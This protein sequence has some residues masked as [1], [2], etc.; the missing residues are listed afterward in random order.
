M[1]A[2]YKI[3]ETISTAISLRDF[4]DK[5]TRIMPE[6]M[7]SYLLRKNNDCW[8]CC[9]TVSTIDKY[10][11]ITHDDAL[12]DII[13]SFEVKQTIYGQPSLSVM[14]EVFTPYIRF[15]VNEQKS[16]WQQLEY[17]D[18]LQMCYLSLCK[19]YNKGYYINDLL[20]RTVFIRDVLL[21]IRKSRT[22][23][24][25][26]SIDNSYGKDDSLHIED[27]L[28]DTY[29][30]DEQD[31][32]EHLEEILYIFDK[33]KT[34]IIDMIGERRFDQLYREYKDKVT[35]NNGRQTL[36]RIKR[37]FAKRNFTMNLF[38]E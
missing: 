34:A 10:N 13:K 4:I 28:E 5:L 22:E 21:S 38:K 35:T 11:T 19:L 12:L 14:I 1:N 33:V 15:L 3:K 25:L 16:H 9:F 18:L 7:Y 37:E 31:N 6:K 2:F 20:L 32:K 23:Y 8:K 17:E 27:T 29:Y 24:T 36:S 30:A 26:V